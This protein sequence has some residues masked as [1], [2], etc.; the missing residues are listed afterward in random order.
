MAPATGTRRRSPGSPLANR[1]PQAG[2]PAAARAGLAPGSVNGGPNAK[3]QLSAPQHPRTQLPRPPTQWA[4][5]ATPSEHGADAWREADLTTD[6]HGALTR[7][8]ESVEG[9]SAPDG[10]PPVAPDGAAPPACTDGA[11]TGAG[12]EGAMLPAI[13]RV[14]Q[15]TA[16]AGRAGSVGRRPPSLT[17]LSSSV[18]PASR[19]GS[20]E[21]TGGGQGDV[22]GPSG[23][24]PA[25]L[26]ARLAASGLHPEVASLIDPRTLPR[27]P[28]ST[29]RR[30][31]SAR[32]TSQSGGRRA[33]RS[34]PGGAGADGLSAPGVLSAASQTQEARA[35]AW[36]A[37]AREASR[38]AEEERATQRRVA[39]MVD[40]YRTAASSLPG[41]YLAARRAGAPERTQ[42]S[43]RMAMPGSADETIK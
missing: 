35:A 21:A 26:S 4:P 7:R 9:V 39:K 11:S 27:P 28:T 32:A 6:R 42:R 1:S 14:Q 5:S 16:A 20:H 36:A 12:A 25:P 23:V 37:E 8:D 43:T 18:R 24:R 29:T 3:R 31:A 38:L 41:H 19:P 17:L 30:I 33:A 34:R 13:G 2:V 22:T 10:V 15:P 40:N